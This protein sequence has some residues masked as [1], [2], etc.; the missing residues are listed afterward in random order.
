MDRNIPPITNVHS[1][2]L[3]IPQTP[4]REVVYGFTCSACGLLIAAGYQRVVIGRRGPYVEFSMDQVHRSNLVHVPKS[5][6]IFFEEYRSSCQEKLFVY[7]QLLPVSY[8]DYLPGF[9]Y[10]DPKSLNVSVGC[11]IVKCIDYDRT[12]GTL[13]SFISG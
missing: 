12:T 4:P 11:K 1:V 10:V 7:Y 9:W 13:D 3:N 5:G 2:A 6:H 8:A